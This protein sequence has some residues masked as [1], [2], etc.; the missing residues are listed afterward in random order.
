[1]S[2]YDRRAFPYLSDEQWKVVTEGCSCGVT[3]LRPWEVRLHLE[4]APQHL[5]RE[6]ER[7]NLG[8]SD[9]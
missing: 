3:G 5:V 2:E 6:I 8:G 4:K 7:R 9:E 1:M